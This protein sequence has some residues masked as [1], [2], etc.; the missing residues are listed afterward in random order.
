MQD[1]PQKCPSE[2][3]LYRID[4]FTLIILQM[5]LTMTEFDRCNVCFSHVHTI[6]HDRTSP[7]LWR[8]AAHYSSHTYLLCG[9]AILH[10]S[11]RY[12]GAITPVAE[13]KVFYYLPPPSSPHMHILVYNVCMYIVLCMYVF[14]SSSRWL[15]LNQL[16]ILTSQCLFNNAFS[17]THFFLLYIHTFS[18]HHLSKLK[19]SS[20]LAP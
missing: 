8:S 2:G 14:M 4:W 3:T 7:M 9:A 11:A 6:L 12:N 20:A 18:P 19:S 1:T 5:D 10:I 16:C 15:P 13:V 17:S